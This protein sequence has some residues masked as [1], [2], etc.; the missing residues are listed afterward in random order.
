VD[1]LRERGLLVGRRCEF[2]RRRQLW[3]LSLQGRATLEAILEDLKR[4]NRWPQQQV[5]PSSCA[6]LRAYLGSLASALGSPVN[7][8][9]SDGANGGGT[10]LSDS[11]HPQT[12]ASPVSTASNVE[13]ALR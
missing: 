3:R 13:G 5:P 1:Q 4:S 6:G 12:I 11:T 9:G 7:P 8:V 10:N 2:D